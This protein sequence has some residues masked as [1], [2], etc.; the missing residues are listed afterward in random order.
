M[1]KGEL[2]NWPREFAA[3]AGVKGNCVSAADD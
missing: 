1:G 3:L 2:R